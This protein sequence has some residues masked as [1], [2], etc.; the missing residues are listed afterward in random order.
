[1]SS[2][3]TD[4]TTACCTQLGTVGD[5]LN[6]VK[7]RYM[8]WDDDY[9]QKA[10]NLV[11]QQQYQGPG[12]T[13]FMQAVDTDINVCRP[14]YDGIGH[15]SSA[16]HTLQSAISTSSATYENE[17]AS[18]YPPYNPPWYIDGP[19]FSNWRN[20]LLQMTL[21]HAGGGGTTAE[22]VGSIL[23]E[24]N[25]A[26]YG[27]YNNAYQAVESLVT[28]DANT[29]AQT[30][31]AEWLP[32][33]QNSDQIEWG[34]LDHY[35]STYPSTPQMPTIDPQQLMQLT[36]EMIQIKQEILTYYLAAF[37]QLASDI[38]YNLTCWASTIFSAHDDFQ[39]AMQNSENY[40]SA[41]DLFDFIQNDDEQRGLY[42]S[43]SSTKPITITPYKTA[44]GKT[45]LLISIGGTD[46]N[47][48]AWDSD[49]FTALQTG[50]GADNPYLEDVRLAIQSYMKEHREM[51]GS[52]I[53]FAGY[54][55]GGMTA[56]QMAADLTS[57]EDQV[58][59]G[60]NLHVAQVITYGSPV[61]GAKLNNV[62]YNMYD[63]T[64]DPV[65][66]LS[67]YENPTVGASQ[68][69]SGGV[70]DAGTAVATLN[71]ADQM[72]WNERVHTYIDPRGQYA[73]DIHEI[74]DAAKQGSLDIPDIISPLGPVASPPIH[75]PIAGNLQ[76]HMNYQHSNQL[77][78]PATA[79][80]DINPATFGP[81]EYFGMKNTDNFYAKLQR[82]YT[83]L[84]NT[85]KYLENNPFLQ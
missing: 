44:D 25:S 36:T 69:Q 56:Q 31:I 65:P 14:I 17:M 32:Q 12:A 28:E 33:Q 21:A 74:T 3:L 66:L 52:E 42:N 63:A 40:L 38:E 81:T 1:M 48:M 16:C 57:G 84:K 73:G 80:T 39:Y 19:V 67:Q 9:Y 6:T 30:Y 15:A 8:Y 11:N 51:A 4:L 75:I 83:S 7:D 61:M 46:F 22:I 45:G 23:Q 68:L 5:T 82:N 55:L 58:L 60:Y 79:T 10:Q 64:Y 53:A 62:Q 37:H 18:L 20:Q 13:A 77:N 43:Q 50:M 24:G 2:W 71:A 76:N 47:D 59:N 41:R 54:S 26:L 85:A 27:A 72:G 70:F 49:I 35:S 29:Y 34:K 78:A